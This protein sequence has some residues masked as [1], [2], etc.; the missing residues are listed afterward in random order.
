MSDFDDIT[1]SE[2]LDCIEDARAGRL[3]PYWQ[4][5][6][7]REFDSLRNADGT[8]PERAELLFQELRKLLDTVPQLSDEQDP[9][10]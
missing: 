8:L 5:Y 7:E 4:G 2:I 10:V 3:S 1:Y 6:A 9:T